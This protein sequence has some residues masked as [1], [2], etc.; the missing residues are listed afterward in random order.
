MYN[1]KHVS[2]FGIYVSKYPPPSLHTVV[3]LVIGLV[4]FV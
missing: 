4:E 1:I 2:V 3:L